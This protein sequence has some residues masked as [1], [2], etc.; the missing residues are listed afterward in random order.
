MHH[1]ICKARNVG[2]CEACSS[3]GIQ[4]P[5]EIRLKSRD[6]YGATRLAKTSVA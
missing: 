5:L 1:H 2:L 6:C 4:W 3:E